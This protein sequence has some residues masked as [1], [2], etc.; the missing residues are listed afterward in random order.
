MACTLGAGL[1][2]MMFDRVGVTGERFTGGAYG[3]GADAGDTVSVRVDAGCACMCAWVGGCGV[4][5]EPGSARPMSGEPFID[6]V[7]TGR[8]APPG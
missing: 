6:A 3:G 1:G 8:D 4:D 7:T 5:C 2:E